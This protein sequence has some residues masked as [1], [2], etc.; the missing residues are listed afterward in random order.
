MKFLK[1]S[2]LN[3]RNVKDQSVSVETDGR[4]TMD[5][6]YSL[7]I[8]KGLT[9][10]RPSNP[11]EG[12]IRYNSTLKEFEA[13]Q[14]NSSTGNAIWR[15]IKFKEPTSLLNFQS[16]IGHSGG[17][18]FGPLTINPFSYKKEGTNSE[19]TL[20]EAAERLIVIV[21]NVIQVANVNYEIYKDPGGY[22]PGAYIHFGSNVPTTKNVYVI[23]G[24]DR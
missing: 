23:S 17:D 14:G 22:V 9:S 1:K 3:F 20:I 13:Y 12:M 18:V 19:L 24:F 10:D 5:G 7:L 11:V 6:K 21:E 16:F 8:P 4:V 2:Q 15:S